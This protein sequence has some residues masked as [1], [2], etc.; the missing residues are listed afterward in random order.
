MTFFLTSLWLNYMELIIP[1]SPASNAITTTDQSPIHVTYIIEGTFLGGWEEKNEQW[2]SGRSNISRRP[3]QAS[4]DFNKRQSHHKT[5]EENNDY[6]E[7]VGKK[8]M[9]STVVKERK[10]KLVSLKRYVEL[11][12]LH[13]FLSILLQMV[14]YPKIV[15]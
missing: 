1:P 3:Q 5:E 15:F 11:Y 8:T 4:N 2:G 10:N 14:L 12:Q 6:W 9:K 13:T 7:T